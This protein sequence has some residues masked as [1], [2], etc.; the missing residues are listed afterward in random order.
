MFFGVVEIIDILFCFP[1]I[2]YD[3]VS[4]DKMKILILNYSLK[5]T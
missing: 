5:N 3:E 4:I 1:Q 2:C